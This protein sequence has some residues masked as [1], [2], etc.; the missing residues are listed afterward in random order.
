MK[1]WR[2]AKRFRVRKKIPVLNL[3]LE[4]KTVEMEV[5][6]FNVYAPPEAYPPYVQPTDKEMIEGL[7][8][9][10][11]FEEAFRMKELKKQNRILKAK[12][13]VLQ[14]KYDGTQQS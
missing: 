9:S 6:K 11:H 4:T 12:L 7:E 2:I 14:K 3:Q 13:T 5:R 8:E 1:N 10:E